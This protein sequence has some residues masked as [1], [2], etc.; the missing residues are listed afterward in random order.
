MV[1]APVIQIDSE[2][3]TVLFRR[4]FQDE[5]FLALN[6]DHTI[7]IAKNVGAEPNLQAVF[8]PL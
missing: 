7:G 2:Q 1:A 3:D 4:Q 8:M 6:P 5:L